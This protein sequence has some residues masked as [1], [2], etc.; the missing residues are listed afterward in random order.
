MYT[1]FEITILSQIPHSR[2]TTENQVELRI[3]TTPSSQSHP[4]FIIKIL[5]LIDHPFDS[6][7]LVTTSL[8]I[9]IIQSFN[10]HQNHFIVAWLHSDRLKL[11]IITLKI[12]L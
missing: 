8:S 4:V 11:L 3:C 10:P 2:S 1:N 5:N 12:L 9:F 6:L 7:F